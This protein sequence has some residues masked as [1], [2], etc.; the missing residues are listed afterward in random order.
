MKYRNLI[1]YIYFVMFE[2]QAKTF[3]K[4]QCKTAA[5]IFFEHGIL[6]RSYFS[7]EVPG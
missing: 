5:L 6:Q 7:D 1:L 3:C 4:C 2:A